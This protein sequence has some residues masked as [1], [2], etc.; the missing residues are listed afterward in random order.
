MTTTAPTFTALAAHDN[1][2][3][4]LWMV[5]G[6]TAFL[7]NDAIIKSL[8]PRVP[9][10]QM[11]VVRGLMAIVLIALVAHRMG[12]L[13]RVGEIVRGWVAV[14]AGCEAIGTFLYL[15]ALFGLPLANATAINQSSPLFIA[16]LA[17]VLLHE[18]V[19]RGR[20]FAIALGF[21]G[22]LLVI[23]PR[24]SEFNGHAWLCLLAT[25][26]YSLRDIFT[27]K[28]GAG[29]PSI[30]ITLATAAT[31]ALL[32]LA[33]L[34]FQ[35]WVPMAW[36]DVGL[37]AL[38]SALLSTGYYAMIAAV[39]H[40]ELSVVAPFRYTGLIW[41]L[42]LGYLVWGDVPNALAWSGIAMLIGAGLF[43]LQPRRSGAAAL[44]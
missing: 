6:M 7:G 22:V 30:L 27:R 8:S 1:R 26:V 15:S 39:R 21:A 19:G 17:M 4:I 25:F 33:V 2:R 41:A 32:A 24:P 12:V 18:R 14:R 28:I 29:T 36:R 38:A 20:W 31:V 16:L 5:G 43:L 40:G 10:A 35:G 44:R 23:Q 9:T 42:V 13:A 34:A 3:G 11:L 37:L